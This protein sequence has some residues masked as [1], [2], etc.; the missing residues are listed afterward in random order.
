MF[1]PF[2]NYGNSIYLVH[3]LSIWN[4]NLFSRLLTILHFSDTHT[5]THLW[6]H[7]SNAQVTQPMDGVYHTSTSFTSASRVQVCRQHTHAASLSL[8]L[9]RTSAARVS[10]QPPLCRRV[11][12]PG[13]ALQRLRRLQSVMDHLNSRVLFC[14]CCFPFKVL[15]QSSRLVVDLFCCCFFSPCQKHLSAENSL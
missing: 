12:D 15:V 13:A 9:C 8:R 5:H 2:I 4:H 11:C 14:C 3:G 6:Q 1:C 7:I 10:P